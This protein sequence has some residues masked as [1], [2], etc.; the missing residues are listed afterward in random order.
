MIGQF[1]VIAL[2]GPAFIVD[3][4]E[5]PI[6]FRTEEEARQLADRHPLCQAYDYVVLDAANGVLASE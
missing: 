1:Y 2:E 6:A 3:E 5:R 4:D